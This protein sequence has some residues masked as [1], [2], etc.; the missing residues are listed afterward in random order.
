MRY[1]LAILT[2][3]V[4][5]AKQPI[6]ESDLLKIARVTEVQVAPDGSLAVYGVQTIHTE[7]AAGP[8]VDPKY[9]YRVNLWSVDLRSSAAKP[10]QLT[11]GEK[12]DSG[13]AIS[14]NG[15][16]LAFVRADDKK[17]PQVWVM[18]LT[19][20]G[21]PRMV[22]DL[23]FGATAPQWRHDSQALVVASAMPVRKLPGKPAF[24]L[25]R[26]NR[27][28][29]DYDRNKKDEAERGSPDGSLREIRDWLEH[30][31]ERND[32]SDINR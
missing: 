14:P 16:E 15:R 6:V 17:L 29:W 5:F 10:L 23:E 25:E 27:D 7:P 8:N 4:C 9:G 28:W 3:V 2:A 1:L 21:E 22:T 26:P 31:S 18:S 30:N 12:T 13:L 32:P 19:G 11:F 20:P 24:S